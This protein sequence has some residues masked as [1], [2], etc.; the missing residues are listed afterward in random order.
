MIGTCITFA[1]VLIDLD[2]G[3]IGIRRHHG[4]VGLQ[5]HDLV[6]IAV[7]DDVRV[8]DDEDEL[9]PALA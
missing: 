6:G 2:L 7:D 4:L 9:S 8:M 5:H 3:C 1:T